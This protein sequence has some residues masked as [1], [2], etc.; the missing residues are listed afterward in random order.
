MRVLVGC[1]FSG[2]VRRAFKLL[3]HEAYSCDLLTSDDDS[4]FHLQ[5]DV[6][7]FLDHDWDLAIFH[8]PCTD[9]AVS[10]SRKFKEKIADGRQ[11]RALDFVQRLMD[12]QIPKIAI[13][14]PISVISSKIRKP[15]Q[16]VQPWMFGH[17]ENKRTCLWLK[18]LPKLTETNNVRHIMEGMP[19]KETDK[20]HYASP[21]PDRWKVRSRTYEGIAQA[22]AEQWGGVA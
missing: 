3:G 22:M 15:D 12:V 10:G 1:E 18:G 9:L 8:P 4:E 7:G 5:G 13:E 16:I 11:Q 2:V 20:V 14:N 17:T 19:K 6:F 21:G